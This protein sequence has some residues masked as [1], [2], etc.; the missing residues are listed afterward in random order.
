V[1]DMVEGIYKLMHSGLEGPPNIGCPQYVS[2]VELVHTVVE[3]SGKKIH[4]R[5]VEGPVD[6]QSR[7]PS[8]DSGHR[9]SNA[10]IYT[11]GWRA[12]HFLEDGIAQTYP[13]I[14]SQVKKAQ[15]EA[16]NS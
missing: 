9:F 14:E 6:V 5:H 1:A 10:R 2:V 4:V 12:N 7:N 15:K 13:W 8:T 3:V 16:R 11:T